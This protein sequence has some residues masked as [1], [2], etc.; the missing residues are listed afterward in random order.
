[1]R[2]VGPDPRQSSDVQPPDVEVERFGSYGSLM[3]PEHFVE[4]FRVAALQ[5]GAVAAYL[6][7]KVQLQSKSAEKTPE[8]QALT[9]VDLATQ[10]VILHQLL[11][12]APHV[13]I[14]AEEDT[15]LVQRFR[16]STSG[17]PLVVIDPVDGTL[18]YARGSQDYA[19]MG[20]LIVDGFFRASVVA[21]PALGLLYSAVRGGG[22]YV[23]RADAHR[24]VVKAVVAPDVALVSPR[25]SADVQR[26]LAE[27][28]QEVQVSRCSAV[29]SSIAALGRA[30]LAVA[31][32][33][34]D[35]RRAIGYLLSAEAGG[36]T[37]HAD[38]P[39]SGEDPELLPSNLEPSI[40]ASNATL[41]LRAL[42]LVR[43]TGL[44]VH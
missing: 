15:E 20:A 13:A 10:D 9:V 18:N 6:Q 40:T 34:S 29:D 32:G 37:Y 16:T 31:E 26:R 21:F 2:S 14:D 11:A 7:G 1:V 22:C 33:R 3:R 35:R 38:R 23:E 25:V 44:P 8:A 41:A 30:R 42:D 12:A 5:A 24:A 17:A 39:W 28:F 36:V 27:N 19:V 4:V 43:G